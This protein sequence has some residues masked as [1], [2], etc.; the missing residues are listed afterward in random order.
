VPPLREAATTVLPSDRALV[1]G[2]LDPRD[3]LVQHGVERGRRLEAEHGLVAIG[4]AVTLLMGGVAEPLASYVGLDFSWMVG[5]NIARGDKLLFGRDLLYTYGPGGFLDH[6]LPLDRFQYTVGIV[7][8]VLV[9]TAL[10]WA[11]YAGLRRVAR[12]E[13]AV[14]VASL[15]AFLCAIK[16]ETSTLLML[17]CAGYV[18]LRL[19]GDVRQRWRPIVGPID[20]GPPVI[21]VLAGLMIQMK[22][23]VG[24]A[25]VGVA[26][27]ACLVCRRWMES[28]LT[29]AAS[30]VCFVVGFLAFWLLLGQQVGYIDEWLSGSVQIAAGYDE[31]LGLLRKDWL[32]SYL[33]A[34]PLA[35]VLLVAAVT[36]FAARRNREVVG[37]LLLVLMLLSFGYRAGFT[38]HDAQHEPQ[39]FTIIVVLLVAVVSLRNHWVTWVA[40]AVCVV[41]MAPPVTAF[42]VE[43][44]RDQWR[45]ALQTI[46]SGKYARESVDAAA[47]AGRD[48][49]QVPQ[50]VL[51][52]AQGHP[53]AFDPWDVSLAVDY[54]LEWRPFPVFQV[55]AAYTHEL[56]ELNADAVRSAPADQRVLRM[57]PVAIDERNPTWESP[58]YVLALACQ[59]A[60]D[61]SEG[62]VS[63]LTN[64]GNWHCGDPSSPRS[65]HVNAGQSV[66]PPEASRNEL[67]VASFTPDSPGLL[68]RLRA[69]VWRP[70]ELKITVSGTQFRVPRG[71]AQGPMLVSYPDRGA[72]GMFPGFSYPTLT[73]NRPGM[74][75]FRTIS[76]GS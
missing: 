60:V 53:V 50:S 22:F 76:I 31:T 66:A 3:D 65:E 35:L 38:R 46:Y 63:L 26:M 44:R 6:P 21:A 49:Y 71:M 51:D 27:L 48:A 13:P 64:T 2:H 19:T 45:I 55:F 16:T 72:D 9:V 8:G 37:L 70:R 57:P 39:V 4:L 11:L 25:A 43:H 29:L 67:V 28:A 17:A 59:Y 69:L 18:A 73:F 61:Q 33:T 30:L 36:R 15:V 1:D 58:E 32:L 5:L 23:S 68:G 7:Y 24:V 41:M 10:W 40:V 47:Q 12:P 34:V 62:A 20:L 42:D 56:D 14:V 52:A 74:V 75:T 54:D